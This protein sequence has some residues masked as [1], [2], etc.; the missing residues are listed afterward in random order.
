M[1]GYISVRIPTNFMKFFFYTLIFCFLSILVL[2]QDNASDSLLN[3][4][5]AGDQ[6]QELL[7]K[8]IFI[9][10]RLLWGEKGLFR[11]THIAPLTPEHREKEMKIRRTML[12]LHQ[13]GGFV[14]LAGMIGQ[15]VVG[16]QLYYHPSRQLRNQHEALASFVNISY[17]TT[18]LLSFTAPPPL[19]NRKGISSIKVHKGLAIVHLTG[20]ILT[21]VLAGALEHNSDLKPYHRAAAYTTFGAYAAAIIVIKF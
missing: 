14:T 21:N 7:P 17:T 2:A 13:I 9:T 18:A 5:S 15:A 6:K 11:V 16:S 19:V 20:M 12:K 10:Q 4:L 3:D 1:F 8:R